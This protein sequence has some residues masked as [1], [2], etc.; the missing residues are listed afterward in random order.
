MIPDHLTVVPRRQARQRHDRR[1]WD[2]FWVYE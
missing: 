1:Q 2:V